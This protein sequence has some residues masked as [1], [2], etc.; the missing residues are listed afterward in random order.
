MQE[1]SVS[2]EEIMSARFIIQSKNKN[3]RRALS[4]TS[5]QKVKNA[6]EVCIKHDGYDDLEVDWI[7]IQADAKFI[8]L[9]IM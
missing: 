5:T 4:D 3:N 7:I 2:I 8:K 9:Q 1:P 6:I